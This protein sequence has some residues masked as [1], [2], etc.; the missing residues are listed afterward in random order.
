MYASDTFPVL[1]GNKAEFGVPPDTVYR[2]PAIGLRPLSYR[3]R[4][5]RHEQ[6]ANDLLAKK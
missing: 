2:S 5:I 4:Y 3:E 6:D 1:S